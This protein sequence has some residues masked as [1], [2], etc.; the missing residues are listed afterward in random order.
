M[1]SEASLDNQHNLNSEQLEDLRKSFDKYDSNK[2]GSICKNDF[3]TFLKTQ[4]DQKNVIPFQDLLDIFDEDGD[5]VIKFKS[6]IAIS[7]P[8]INFPCYRHRETFRKVDKDS[9]GMISSTDI[10]NFVTEISQV[11]N[12]QIN[13]NEQTNAT[14]SFEMQTIE[15]KTQDELPQDLLLKEMENLL[16]TE[17]VQSEKNINLDE[18][19]D[20]ID[21]F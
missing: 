6:F 17:I 5:G 2:D 18:F 1:I 21:P 11:K 8:N 3:E 15:L 19:M 10:Q 4:E 16:K 7:N 14:D 9:D 12:L 20:L 13:T